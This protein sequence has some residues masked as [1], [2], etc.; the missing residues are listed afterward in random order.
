MSNQ[1]LREE[2]KTANSAHRPRSLAEKR[3]RRRRRLAT[4][5]RLEF[6]LH[7]VY[8]LLFLTVTLQLFVVLRGQIT[9]EIVSILLFFLWMIPLWSLHILSERSALRI[10][11]MKRSYLEYHP[12][13]D[14]PQ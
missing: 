12:S 10:L 8:L 4:F 11:K 1:P 5:D 9:S 3:A 2:T 13:I 6:H 7:I 14:A